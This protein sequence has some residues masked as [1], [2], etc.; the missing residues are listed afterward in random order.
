VVT[1]VSG[2]T[3]VLCAWCEKEGWKSSYWPF[4]IFEALVNQE[5]LLT[6]GK[7]NVQGL[8]GC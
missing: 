5:L 7:Q 6:A 1:N 3:L 4:R 8:E 2:Y